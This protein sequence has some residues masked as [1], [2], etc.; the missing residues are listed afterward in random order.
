LFR[1]FS[2]T[3]LFLEG[4]QFFLPARQSFF[5]YVDFLFIIW[6]ALALFGK[7]RKY[8]FIL[9][10]FIIVGSFPHLFNTTTGDFSGHLALMFPFMI[11]L[12]GAGVADC[13]DHFR[14]RLRPVA[15][16]FI[17]LI[18]MLN[19]ASF[20]MIYF[21][22]YPLVGSSDFPMRILSKYITLARQTRVPITVYSTRSG[23][24]LSK[25]LFYSNSMNTQTLPEIS[26][27]HTQLPFTFNQ[28]HFTNCD[29]AETRADEPAGILIYDQ[30]C[31]MHRDGTALKI[32][33]LLDGG[34][35][36]GIFNDTVCGGYSLNTYP[37]GIT[38]RNLEVEQL[39]AE[40]FCRVYI[41]R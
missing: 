3:Y 30:I 40:E 33:S 20:S 5:Y 22:Q 36:Y 26:R 16:G 4:D 17:G 15:L 2:P 41:S 8:L 19:V 39:P 34:E 25:Y 6:G 29:S 10:G 11:L 12:I 9:T 38:I 37:N 32:S 18:Y 14:G 24:L 1:I 7:N 21:F 31:A 28:I 13:I 23:D 27:L 35:K